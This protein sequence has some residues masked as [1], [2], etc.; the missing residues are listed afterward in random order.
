MPSR[1]K[2][3]PRIAAE[4]V[5][6]G[7]RN[8][9][10]DYVDKR[11]EYQ[12]AGIE[13]YWIIDPQARRITVL[14]LEGNEYRVHGEFVPGQKATSAMF[15][16]FTVEVTALFAVGEGRTE[17]PRKAKPKRAQRKRKQ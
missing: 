11:Q 5:S 9:Q 13:E 3:P 4:F 8:R 14:A 7:R 16:E 17:E 15:S 6:S 12:E 10:R 1:R 2:D